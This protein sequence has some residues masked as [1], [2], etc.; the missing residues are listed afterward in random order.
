MYQP[1]LEGVVL[2]KGVNLEK[3]LM[4]TNDIMTF[5]EFPF[6]IRTEKLGD[7]SVIKEVFLYDCWFVQS[8]H[9]R[10]YQDD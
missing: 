5:D 9:R 10:Q 1:C 3:S 6:H 2:E 8:L 7:I 4:E